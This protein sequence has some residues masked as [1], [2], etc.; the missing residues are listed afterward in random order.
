MVTLGF[1][2]RY[3]RPAISAPDDAEIN[4]QI[5]KDEQNGENEMRVRRYK[6][7]I[8]NCGNV[9]LDK[10]AFV[11]GFAAAHCESNFPT[12]SVDKTRRN[13]AREIPRRAQADEVSKLSDNAKRAVRRR[14][15]TARS[16]D[17][18]LKL[19]RL[20]NEKSSQFLMR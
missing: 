20:E 3:L 6:I 1:K 14:S 18:K 15:Q 9:M 11:S 7:G 13:T 17:E 4:K 16:R 12:S 2:Q 8:N 19:C 10:S 5:K